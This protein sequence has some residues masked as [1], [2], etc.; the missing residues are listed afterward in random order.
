M[1]DRYYFRINVTLIIVMLILVG[2]FVK[3]GF[4]QLYRASEKQ[5]IEEEIKYSS[6]LPPLILNEVEDSKPK[7]RFRKAIVSG[8]YLYENNIYL[9]GK[10]YQ[11]DIGYEVLTPLLIDGT[12]NLQVFVNRGW[13]KMDGNGEKLPAVYTPKGKIKVNGTIVFST[14]PPFIK[15]PSTDIERDWGERWPFLDIDYYTAQHDAKVLPFFIQQ[16]PEDQNSFIRQWPAFNAKY[17]MHI[18]YAIQWFVFAV[19]TILVYLG[20]SIVQKNNTKRINQ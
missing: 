11:N 6:N 19:I 8:K 7:Y 2:V 12:E 15:L 16:S 4:W 5:K 14:P 10:K 9:D 20:L 3:L 1:F 17:F 18:G 13:V